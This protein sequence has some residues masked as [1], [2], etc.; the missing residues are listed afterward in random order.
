MMMLVRDAT[1]GPHSARTHGPAD[2]SVEGG[3]DSIEGKSRY[4]L[5]TARS[6]IRMPAL[7]IPKNLNV[8]SE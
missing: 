1:R 4:L 2:L 7:E 3:K 5:L 6:K 8:F